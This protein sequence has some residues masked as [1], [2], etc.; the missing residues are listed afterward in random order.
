MNGNTTPSDQNRSGSALLVVLVML[1]VIAILAAAVARSVSGAA[2]ELSAAR[3]NQESESDVRAGI[4]LGAA[5]IFKLGDEM[6]SA[7]AAVDLKGRRITVR[8]TNERARIDLNKAN[9]NV[10]TGLLK[11]EGIDDGEATSLVANIVEWRGGADS[12][13]PAGPQQDDHHFGA[14]AGAVSFDAPTGFASKPAPKKTPTLRFFFH[15][16]Q[17]VSVPGF[18]KTLVKRL[19]P[20][21]TVANGANKINPFI[22]GPDVLNAL[23][24]ATRST[25]EAFL[26]A[27]DGNVSRDTAIQLLGVGKDLLSEEASSG[28]RLQITS[29][30]RV[31]RVRH[32]EAVIGG[33][34]GDGGGDSYHVLYVLDDA[35]HYARPAGY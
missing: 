12:E 26:D 25:V 34:N 15:P 13:K 14:S 30:P 11:A 10:L 2:L 32:S 23:P 4:E 7:D 17:L 9:R 19:F 33:I 28:W 1:G 24:G 3:H 5:A 6:R 22:A 31:G 35:D 8:V 29:T 16:I 27:R 18:S 21:L 20:L